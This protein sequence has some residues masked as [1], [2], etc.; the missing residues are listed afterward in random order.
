MSDKALLAAYLRQQSEVDM[1]DFPMS[2]SFD[3]G[4]FLR[5]IVR[6]RSPASRPVG[7]GA[8]RAFA[9]PARTT[10]AQKVPAALPTGFI[11]PYTRLSRIKPLTSVSGKSGPSAI[12]VNAALPIASLQPLTYDEKRAVFKELYA[13]R[14]GKCPLSETRKSFVFGAGNVNARLM[15]VGEAPGADED[16]QGMPFVGAAGKL[17]TILLQAVSSI[18]RKMYLLPMC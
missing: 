4:G 11:D 17:L 2:P 16:E 12:P 9:A 14:C 3:L 13:A 7:A 10:R 1:P 18:A 15:I 5:S 6:I 8:K